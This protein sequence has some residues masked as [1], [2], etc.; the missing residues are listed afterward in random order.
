MLSTKQA[1]SAFLR[2]ALHLLCLA[3]LM[4][5]LQIKPLHAAEPFVVKDIRVEGLQRVEPGTVF[6][7][8]P[9]Q[10]G[11]RFTDEKAAE[12][13]KALYATGF[14]RDVQIQAQGDVLIVIVDERPTISR[15][16]FTGMK[17]F[18]QEVVRKS[19]RTVGVADARFYDKALIDKAEQELKRQY[20]S[21]GLF[22]A[23]VVTTVT[24][25]ARNQVAIF[26]NIDEGPVAKIKE[27]NFIGNKAFSESTL[28]G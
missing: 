19:L 8:L 3:C 15:I 27:I 6:S 13:I 5:V 11:E 20:V 2:Q 14:F 12:S 18:D 10:V 1:P 24:P 21:K 22:A 17:E 4:L 7:Y 26:F 28:R 23:E 9:V 16:E 25:G